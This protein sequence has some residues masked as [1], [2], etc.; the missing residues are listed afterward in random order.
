M[1]IIGEELEVYLPWL[2][3]SIWRRRWGVWKRSFSRLSVSWRTMGKLQN[4]SLEK[5]PPEI[6]VEEKARFEEQR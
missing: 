4:P 1:E 5:A 3:W 2:G 6:V